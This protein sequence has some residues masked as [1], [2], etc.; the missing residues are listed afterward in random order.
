M[1]LFTLLNFTLFHKSSQKQKLWN[2]QMK[3][4]KAQK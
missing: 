3:P 1:A 4:E 2:E